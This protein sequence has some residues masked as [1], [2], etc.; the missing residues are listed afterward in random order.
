MRRS[1]VSI[2]SAEFLCFGKECGT[3][4]QCLIVMMK[5]DGVF[6][7]MSDELVSLG[8]LH[9]YE[10]IEICCF[11]IMLLF[12]AIVCGQ[13]GEAVDGRQHII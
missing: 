8:W 7:G 4:G 5:V 13:G 12:E 10:M 6:V 2:S 11:L 9:L 1:D 3:K